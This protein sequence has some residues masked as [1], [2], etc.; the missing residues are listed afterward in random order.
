MNRLRQSYLSRGIAIFFFLFT[1][2]DLATPHLCAEEMGLPFS[3]V[4]N[5]VRSAVDPTSTDTPSITARDSHQEE[6]PAPVPADEDCFCCCS[7][8]LPG[9]HF[10]V[11]GILFETINTDQIVSFLPTGP[12]GKPYHPPRLS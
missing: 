9:L 2:V 7:H 4:G 11:D 8:I 6:S 3:P 10:V 1:V 5:S 12:P